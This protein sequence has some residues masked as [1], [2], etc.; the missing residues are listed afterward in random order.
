LASGLKS[1]YNIP[2]TVTAMGQG[3]SASVAVAIL[4]L[5]SWETV[6]V[7]ARRIN[8]R[9]D[10]AKLEEGRQQAH[11]AWIEYER[12]KQQAAAEGIEFT[13]PSPAE[14]AANAPNS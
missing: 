14:K 6:M 9:R 5:A 12:R 10:Q 8:E 2:D 1:L 4:S 11:Q 7:I 13:E 3:I